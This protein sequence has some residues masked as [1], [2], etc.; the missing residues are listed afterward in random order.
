MANHCDRYA[1]RDI[2]LKPRFGLGTLRGKL[3]VSF[4][5]AV[6]GCAVLVSLANRR[7]FLHTF[8]KAIIGSAHHEAE[9]ASLQVSE[10]MAEGRSLDDIGETLL[11]ENYGRLCPV[12]V[13]RLNPVESI[14]PQLP[15]F[16]LVDTDVEALRL[17]RS[18]EG[19]YSAHQ[20]VGRGGHYSAVPVVLDKQVVAAVVAFTV[21]PRVTR[22]DSTAAWLLRNLALIL[23]PASL[24]AYGLTTHL[25]SPIT[26]LQQ[27]TAQLKR[28]DFR[29]RSGL[30]RA[31]EI[32]T[33]A[34]TFDLMA[35]RIESHINTR[36]RLLGDISHELCTPLTTLR[37]TIEALL[38]DVV[39]DEKE[40]RR[41]LESLL[42]QVEHLSFLV[43]DLTELTR[44]ETGSMALIKEP[45]M[46]GEP[47]EQAVEPTLLLAQQRGI[48]VTRQTVEASVVGDKRRIMQ[49]L[50]NL[51][52]NAII[53]NPEGITIEVQAA[54]GEKAVV[55][56]VRDNGP[57]IPEEF[58]ESLFERFYKVDASRTFGLAGAGLGLS[59]VREILRAHGSDIE[60]H[61]QEGRKIFRF[62]LPLA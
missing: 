6:V 13:V 40:R 52:T 2:G 37:V 50:K 1:A 31:D 46:A 22:R 8:V 14:A 21:R 41:C 44:F 33:L 45:F 38:D 16:H 62:S 53:H 7:Y 23:L 12:T 35:A 10:W 17:G 51:L 11:R 25:L 36:T 55:F 58:R 39:E 24:L 43:T 29:A 61:Q 3:F 48:T 20:L 30:D 47:V 49:V 54:L 56:E 32:G 26:R 59:I 60:F 28:G 34:H 42:R 19:A 27:A 9:I 57:P 5:L 4:V 18:V 15:T